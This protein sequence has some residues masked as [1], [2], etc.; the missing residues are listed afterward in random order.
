MTCCNHCTDAGEIFSM[1]TAARDLKRYK[2][3]GPDKSTRLLLETIRRKGV[4]GKTLLDI[5]GGIGVITFELLKDGLAESV[6]VDAS[7]GYLDESRKE[8]EARGLANRISYEY[9][10]FTDLAVK[11]KR[12]IS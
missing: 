1:K 11:V 9:G 6:H 4:Q 12:Q 10:D 8:A 2:R 3:K 5:G 7:A